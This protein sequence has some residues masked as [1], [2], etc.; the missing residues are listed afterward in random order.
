MVERYDGACWRKDCAERFA[1]KH[2][3]LKH[4]GKWAAWPTDGFLLLEHLA[5]TPK[6]PENAECFSPVNG[7][8][9]NP[10]NRRTALQ[11]RSEGRGTG[12][13]AVITE[14]ETTAE[15]AAA[16]GWRAFSYQGGASGAGR[17]DYS[18]IAGMDVL[19][20]PDND[21]PGTKAALTAAIRCIEAGAR[22]VRIRPT[23]AFTGAARTWP[24]WTPNNG[25]WSSRTAGSLRCA[26]WD[27][28][29]WT[30]PSTT[31]ATVARRRPG[32]R[33]WP[34]P[35]R[36]IST[37]TSVRCGPAYSGARMICSSPACTSGTANWS[38]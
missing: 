14:G 12:N 10:C 27:R 28:C 5:A 6:T 25:C 11:Q 20:A 15:A 3:Y 36:S 13:W 31:W 37:T 18:P 22:E 34:P 19:I 35:S 1:H 16:C 9:C 30:S 38:T 17:A 2:P 26:S 21:R 24:T 29:T 32:D 23:D 4:R 7:Q 8:P 33:W